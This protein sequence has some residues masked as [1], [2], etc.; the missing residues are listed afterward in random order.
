MRPGDA[1]DDRHLHYYAEHTVT[2]ESHLLRELCMPQYIVAPGEP[3]YRVIKKLGCTYSEILHAMKMDTFY[4]RRIPRLGGRRGKPVPVIYCEGLLDPNG[5]L[6]HMPDKV[7]S[8][9]LA[10]NSERIPD[11][12]S[13]PV[14]R[15]P[16]YGRGPTGVYD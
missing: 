10:Y 12:I 8:T 4:L 9:H 5:P 7:W 15:R 3:A 16:T 6:F 2:L 11:G 13:Q 1:C 14:T